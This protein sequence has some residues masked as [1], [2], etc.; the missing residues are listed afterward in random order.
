M[1]DLRNRSF[2]ES[3]GSSGCVIFLPYV[4]EMHELA[5]GAMKMQGGTAQS[6]ASNTLTSGRSYMLPWKRLI[7][8]LI[9]EQPIFMVRVKG[10]VFRCLERRRT[11][12][13]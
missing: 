8:A 5:T 11:I 9:W 1:P 7:Q 4:Q 3:P 6:D 2:E 12:R 13:E 10:Y